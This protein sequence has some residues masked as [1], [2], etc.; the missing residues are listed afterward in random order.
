[1]HK[2]IFFSRKN[3][4]L[5]KYVYS[6]SKIFRPVT[7]NKLIFYLTLLYGSDKP[8]HP[9]ILLVPSHEILV[10][11][12]LSSSQGSNKPL[13][14]LILL[15][16]SHEI[17]VLIVLLSSQGSDK[18]L[19]PLILLVPSHEILVLIVLLSSQGSDKTFASPHSAS[20]KP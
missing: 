18:P 15:V 17:L 9:L 11:I 20:A 8:L 5:K 4:N 1:M 7:R 2:I 3:N 19:H 10:L 12:V 6:L 14:P 13:H 16:P